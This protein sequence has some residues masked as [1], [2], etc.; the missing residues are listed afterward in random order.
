MK[1]VRRPLRIERNFLEALARRCPDHPGILRPLGDLY[2]R[3]GQIAKGLEVDQRLTQLLPN[4]PIT[5][6]NLGCS[7]ALN[8]ETDRALE[9]LDLATRHGYRDRRWMLQDRD[10]QSLRDDPRFLD[11]VARI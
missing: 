11:L 10:L 4:D 3:V 1:R 2:T 8:G 7:Y 9:A 6:Y 5:W